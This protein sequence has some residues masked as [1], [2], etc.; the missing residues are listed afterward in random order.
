MCKGSNRHSIIAYST[1]AQ[2]KIMR[3]MSRVISSV[4]RW[5]EG[6]DDS[7][8]GGSDRGDGG[9]GRGLGGDEKKMNYLNDHFPKRFACAPGAWLKE[10]AWSLPRIESLSMQIDCVFK[11]K[12]NTRTLSRASCNSGV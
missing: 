4:C 10:I 12:V 2:K 1:C 3:N 11:V 7:S 8:G 9:G 5:S 6:K